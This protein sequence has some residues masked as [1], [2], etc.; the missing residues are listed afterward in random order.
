MSNDI[1]TS[2]KGGEKNTIP[3]LISIISYNGDLKPYVDTFLRNGENIFKELVIHGFVKMF[4]GSN[5]NTKIDQLT[6][7][8]MLTGKLI[9]TTDFRRKCS[10]H[11]N[12]FKEVDTYVWCVRTFLR[13]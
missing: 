13:N 11:E 2:Y 3:I 12:I 4:T 5:I 10:E 1:S 8:W 6:C 9:P 7:F